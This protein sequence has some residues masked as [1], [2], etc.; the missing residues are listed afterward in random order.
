[1][2][3]LT[4]SE[5]SQDLGNVLARALSGEPIGITSPDGRIVAL[6]PVEE[7]FEDASGEYGLS[8]EELDRAYSSVEKQV[9]EERKAGQLREL[10]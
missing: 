7:P 5:A 2:T 9:Q 10:K 3:T 6:R 1:M 8:R 4:T